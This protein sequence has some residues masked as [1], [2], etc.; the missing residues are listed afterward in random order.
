M[1]L[2]LDVLTA[3]CR[4]RAW[5]WR[6]EYSEVENTYYAEASG[7][8]KGKFV[9]VKRDSTIEDAIYRLLRRVRDWTPPK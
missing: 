9:E 7:C 1:G 6:L 4:E 5:S 8:G 3:E 2:Y